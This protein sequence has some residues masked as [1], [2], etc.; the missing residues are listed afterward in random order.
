MNITTFD[1]QDKIE[2][3]K[4]KFIIQNSAE[5]ESEKYILTEMKKMTQEYYKP[6]DIDT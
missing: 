4:L 2:E 3:T 1:F 5:R 6:S